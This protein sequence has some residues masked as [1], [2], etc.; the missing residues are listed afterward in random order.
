MFIKIKCGS[1]HKHVLQRKKLK[2]QNNVKHKILY[3]IQE[4]P[5]VITY[6]KE[7]H[8]TKISFVDKQ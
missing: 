4:S 3:R 8:V 7:E 6:D 1:H 2:L 5:F